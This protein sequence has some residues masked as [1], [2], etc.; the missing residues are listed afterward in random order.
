V[1]DDKTIVTQ[2]P[3]P[4]CGEY[5]SRRAA[6][7]PSCGRSFRGRAWWVLTIALALLLSWLLAAAVVVTLLF[8][9][10]HTPFWWPVKA[11]ASTNRR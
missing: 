7:C 1:P 10:G 5:R 9:S 6:A 2:V 3:C 8:L 4:D 11:P